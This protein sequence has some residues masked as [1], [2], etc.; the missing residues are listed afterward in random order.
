MVVEIMNSGFGSVPFFFGGGWRGEVLFSIEWKMTAWGTKEKA[1]LSFCFRFCSFHRAN[2]RAG[3]T[4]WV[5][6]L[7]SL[8][9]RVCVC[10]SNC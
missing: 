5:S 4:I 2:I 7:F 10:V 6:M 9:L 3:G 8:L 1:A